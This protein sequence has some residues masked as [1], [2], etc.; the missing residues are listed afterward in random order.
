[1]TV[2]A[3]FIE[4]LDERGQAVLVQR[5]EIAVVRDCDP[6]IAYMRTVLV[7]KS[8][9]SI[10]LQTDFKTVLKRLKEDKQ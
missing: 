4:F 6:T 5:D 2:P 1:M 3:D 9:E 7:L 10:A 8:G